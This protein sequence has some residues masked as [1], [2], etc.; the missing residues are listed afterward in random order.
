MVDEKRIDARENPAVGMD[1][2]GFFC[3]RVGVTLS[4]SHSLAQTCHWHV[5]PPEWET[6]ATDAVII[7]I[8]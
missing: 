1:A 3:V 5:C 7:Y 8:S 4:A 2:A 6:G